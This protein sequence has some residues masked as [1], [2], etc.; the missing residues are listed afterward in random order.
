M[1]THNV[2]LSIFDDIR[3]SDY[4]ASSD[5]RVLIGARF[6]LEALSLPLPSCITRKP[7]GRR[8]LA[9][10]MAAADADSGTSRTYRDEKLRINE[11]APR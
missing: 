4:F 6:A 1:S 9:A 10:L 2:D 5:R 8:S 3:V 7:A 11:A